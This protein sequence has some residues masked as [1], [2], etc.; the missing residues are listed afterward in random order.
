LRG[1]ERARI[2]DNLGFQDKVISDLW[3][4]IVRRSKPTFRQSVKGRPRWWT[5]VWRGQIF[6]MLLPPGELLSE[7]EI[8]T[9][10]RVI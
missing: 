2:Y 10:V 1:R 7:V 6:L 4:G 8:E 5:L 3:I 9:D